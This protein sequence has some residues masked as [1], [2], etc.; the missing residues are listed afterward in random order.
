MQAQEI[1]SYGSS[2]DKFLE[3]HRSVAIACPH[4][5]EMRNR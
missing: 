3:H 5:A 4:E 2:A 1:A